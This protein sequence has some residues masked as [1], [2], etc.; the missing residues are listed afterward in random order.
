MAGAHDLTQRESEVA[1]LIALRM[2]NKQIASHLGIEFATVKN[3]VHNILAKLHVRR[4][5]E[6]LPP[7]RAVASHPGVSPTV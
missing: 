3:H 6:I 7:V 5:H 4:R 2:S 1:E